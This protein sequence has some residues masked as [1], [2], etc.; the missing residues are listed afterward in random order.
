MAI[1]LHFHPKSSTQDMSTERE[2]QH[3]QKRSSHPGSNPIPKSQRSEGHEQGQRGQPS[4]LQN[5]A[6]EVPEVQDGSLVPQGVPAMSSLERQERIVTIMN[7]SIQG[8]GEV[9][10]RQQDQFQS[11]IRALQGEV[12]PPTP[13]AEGVPFSQPPVSAQNMPEDAPMDMDHPVFETPEK[14][15]KDLQRQLGEVQKKLKKNMLIVLNCK[16]RVKNTTTEL[17]KLNKGEIP[18]GNAPFK[19]SYMCEEM[20][21]KVGKNR[22]FEIQFNAEMTHKQRLE[23]LYLGYLHEK[24]SMEVELIKKRQ[25]EMEKLCHF[26]KFEHEM[27]GIVTSKDQKELEDLGLTL[28]PDILKNSEKSAKKMAA[29]RFRDLIRTF[30]E[31]RLKKTRRGR[32]KQDGKGQ[33]PAKS[34]YTRCKTSHHKHDSKC[35]RSR[36]RE[37]N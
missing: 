29:L 6:L 5:E 2:R 3:H 32:K 19:M 35:G 14:I 37:Q 27:V 34:W 13:Q 15:P 25:E 24:K 1:Y 31:E 33:N 16:D 36:K 28:G 18:N 20:D 22:K 30:K 21:E 4:W 11:A 12:P 23:R 10:R 8:L 17:E 7:E 9:L 26:E